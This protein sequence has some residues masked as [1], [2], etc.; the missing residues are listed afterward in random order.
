MSSSED[1]QKAF[2]A[3]KAESEARQ[4]LRDAESRRK[5]RVFSENLDRSFLRAVALGVAGPAFL[6][7]VGALAD[8]TSRALIA[9]MAISLVGAL[10]TLAGSYWAQHRDPLW[11]ARY[12]ALEDV[13]YF[14]IA[15]KGKEIA[16]TREVAPG[17][18]IDLDTA[19]DIVGI[20]VIRLRARRME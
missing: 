7:L 5:L 4:Q 15:P 2:G 11:T 3:R 9:A 19:G 10:G 13:A 16:E 20:E 18:M 6:I 12:D 1:A 8:G 14:R 17:V